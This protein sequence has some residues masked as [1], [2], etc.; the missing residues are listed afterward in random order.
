MKRAVFLALLLLIAPA[1][2]HACSARSFQPIPVRPDFVVVVGH[3]SKPVPG[4]EIVVTPSPGAS[5]FLTVST[6]E[7]GA[8]EL[9]NL[10][11][12]NTG[13]LHRTEASKPDGN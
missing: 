6:D 1:F 10:P 12:G 3:R 5:A 9:H 4:V 13:W 7:N 11:A 8:A 2:A